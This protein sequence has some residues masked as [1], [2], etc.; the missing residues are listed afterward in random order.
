MIEQGG[1][2]FHNDFFGPPWWFLLF[3]GIV[4]AMIAFTLLKGVAQWMSNNA[5]PVETAMATV[6]GKRTSTSGGHNTSVTTHYYVTFQFENQERREFAVSG[7]EYGMLVEND[8]GLLT[9][10]G[11]RYKGLQRRLM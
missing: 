2:F 10:Q 5:S 1:F 6:I 11:T 8:T 3:A 9:Y 7:K 4:I